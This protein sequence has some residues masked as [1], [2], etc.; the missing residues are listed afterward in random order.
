[1]KP[2][3]TTDSQGRLL[4]ADASITLATTTR[5]DSYRVGSQPILGI[6]VTNNSPDPCVRD[7]SG[8]LQV[9][10]VYNAQHQRIWSTA[11]CFPGQGTESWM[12]GP[13]QSRHFDIKWAGTTSQPGCAG[14]R[15]PVPTGSY[16]AV[17]QLGTL[18]AAPAK[19][20]ITE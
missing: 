1:M 4:C 12:F 18:K 8:T 9:F 10:T 16:T 7:V 17:A 20:A 2:V 15:V 5:V 13:G 14:Q 6:T 11:D 19:F 3:P